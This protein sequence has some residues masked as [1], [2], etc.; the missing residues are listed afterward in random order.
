[1]I[2]TFDGHF[3]ITALA[4]NASSLENQ[5]IGTGDIKVWHRTMY[6]LDFGDTQRVE[7][8]QGTAYVREAAP[9]EQFWKAWRKNKDAVKAAGFS[10]RKYQDEW[11]VSFWSD[12][13]DC[14]LPES[15]T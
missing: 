12:R 15:P 7:T 13:E 10:L 3:S 5:A 6:G 1:M 4:L 2:R 11:V 8:R 9:T 14:P